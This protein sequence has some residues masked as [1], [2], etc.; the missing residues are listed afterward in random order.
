MYDEFKDK[1]FLIVALNGMDDKDTI[2]K[3]ITENKFTFTIG[4]KEGAEK[5]N[6]DEQFG[7]MAYP[8]NYLIGPD[9]KV[10][11]RCVGFDEPGIRKALEKAGVK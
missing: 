7:V 5:Y 3:Y 4:M 11:F 10:L 8:T 9:G 2:Q 1:G 6:V